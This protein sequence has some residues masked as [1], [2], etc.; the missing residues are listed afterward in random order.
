MQDHMELKR[1]IPEMRVLSGTGRFSD[2]DI[3]AIVSYAHDKTDQGRSN[4]ATALSGL[5]SIPLTDNEKKLAG[6]ILSTL[7]RQAERDVREARRS[8]LP[9]MTMC[10]RI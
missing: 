9:P 6:E 3:R 8:G 1:D 10:R 2:S 5:F 7:V 4:L